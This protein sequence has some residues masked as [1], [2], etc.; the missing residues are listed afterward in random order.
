[1]SVRA[2]ALP[3]S[4]FIHSYSLNLS[5]SEESPAIFLYEIKGVATHIMLTSKNANANGMM[6]TVN[7]TF[8]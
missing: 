7:G 2:K 5:V 6:G 1:M 8:I 4:I 3:Y